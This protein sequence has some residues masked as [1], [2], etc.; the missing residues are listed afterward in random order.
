MNLKNILLNLTFKDIISCNK[1]DVERILKIRNEDS[2]R[3][4]MFTKRIISLDEH[5]QWFEDLKNKNDYKFYCIAYKE[6]IIGGL[7]I[8]NINE[9][10]KSA[11]W[12]FYITNSTKAVGVGGAIEFK[13]I[14]YIFKIYKIHDLFCYVLKENIEVIKL[15]KKFGFE[16]TQI[17]EEDLKFMLA[18]EKKNV[19]KFLLNFKK[20]QDQKKIISEM[21]FKNE[22]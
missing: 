18:N 9:S 21:Y 13:A 16:K 8:K 20:W 4:N 11:E 12:A 15:H 3:K 17:K 10:L 19:S 2:V 5:E 1:E 6:K 14:E 7:G 22:S